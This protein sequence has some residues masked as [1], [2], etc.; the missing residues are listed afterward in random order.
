[1]KEISS[2]IG[3][4]LNDIKNLI[5]SSSKLGITIKID[6]SI[7][8]ENSDDETAVAT[9]AGT[10]FVKPSPRESLSVVDEPAQWVSPSESGFEEA[11]KPRFPLAPDVI[12]APS[13]NNLIRPRYKPEIV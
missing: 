3:G 6:V 2:D 4:F 5:A 11:P 13:A 7:I 1:M 10:Y 8:P 12:D 9:I